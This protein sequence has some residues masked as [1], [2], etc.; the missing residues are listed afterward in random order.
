MIVSL[1]IFSVIL[2]STIIVLNNYMNFVVALKSNSEKENYTIIKEVKNNKS[3]D[4]YN[5]DSKNIIIDVDCEVIGK[6]NKL[7]VNKKTNR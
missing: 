2:L 4:N 5:N 7:L 3:Y 1:F 6:N